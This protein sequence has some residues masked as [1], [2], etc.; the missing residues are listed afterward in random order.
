MFV[1]CRLNF[2][3]FQLPWCSLKLV[4]WKMKWSR[5][6]GVHCNCLH[7]KSKTYFRCHYDHICFSGEH[8]FL[9][10][11]FETRHFYL[12]NLTFFREHM[13]LTPPHMK[14]KQENVSYI[15]TLFA[16]LLCS[17]VI[18]IFQF[19]LLICTFLTFTWINPAHPP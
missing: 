16:P 10:L 8:W 12:L 17:F 6:N 14:R 5:N 19:T 13:Q 1:Y 4:R 3:R 7:Q 18:T 2:H 9:E 15:L 11:D